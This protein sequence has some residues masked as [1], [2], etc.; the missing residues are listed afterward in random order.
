MHHGRQRRLTAPDH[1]GQGGTVGR[2]TRDDADP[3][4][5]LRQFGAQFLGPRRPRAPACGQQQVSY[6]VRGDQVTGEFGAE[7][8]GASGDEHRA[9]RSEG[10]LRVR[11][12]RVRGLLDRGQGGNRHPPVPHPQLRFAGRDGRG[13]GPQ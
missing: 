11:V 12:L 10:G 3:R 4:A 1:L 2:V 7:G 8:P 5:R 6:A 13:Q 9:V